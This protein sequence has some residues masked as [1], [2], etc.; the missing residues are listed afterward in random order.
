MKQ[1]FSKSKLLLLCACLFTLWCTAEASTMFVKGTTTPYYKIDNGSYAQMTQN[2]T[3]SDNAVWYY[4]DVASGSTVTFATNGSGSNASPAITFDS[5]ADSYFEYNGTGYG[6]NLTRIK[7][8]TSYILL[9]I[10]RDDWFITG[11]HSYVYAWGNSGDNANWPGEKVIEQNN[12]WGGTYYIGGNNGG[13]SMFLW[14]SN[15]MTPTHLKVFRSDG[16]NN[17]W[18]SS[19]EQ[20]YYKGDLYKSGENWYRDNY[21]M[22]NNI[23]WPV[24]INT[25]KLYLV[26]NANGNPW[27]ANV[28]I[29]MTATDDTGMKFKAENVLLTPGNSGFAFA[30]ML[31]STSND[32]S[33]LNDHRYGSTANSS[34]WLITESQLGMT[35]NNL[36]VDNHNEKNFIVETAGYYNVE[37]DL[38]AM[39]TKVTRVYGAL[40]MHYGTDAGLA[41]GVGTSMMTNDGNTYTLSNVALAENDEFVFTTQLT[42]NWN[43]NYLLG[44]NTSANFWHIT[45]GDLNTELSQSLLAGQGKRFRMDAG[46]AGTYRVVVN[47]TNNSVTLY[48]MATLQGKVIIHLEQT[49]NVSDPV[50]WAYDKEALPN[51]TEIHVDRPD[52]NVI[53]TNRKKLNATRLDDVTVGGRTWWSWEVDDAMTDFWFTRGSYDYANHTSDLTHTDMTDI[54]WRK[55]GEL[56]YT[57]PGTSNTLEDYTRDYYTAAAQEAAVCA[58][59]IDGHEY[60]YF[61]NTPG[62][63]HVYCHAWYTDANGNN[64]DLLQ[65]EYITEPTGWYPGVMCDMVGYDKDG[66]EVWRI[67]L[68]AHGVTVK[69]SGIIFNNGVYKNHDYYTNAANTYPAQQTSD[70]VYSTGT[71]YDY[72][73]VITLGSSLA[74][75][76]AKGVSGPP[77]TIADD[78]VGVYVD[79]NA[80]T[81]ITVDGIDHTV[82]GALY[83]KDLN[84]FITTSYVEKSQQQNGEIDY[85]LDLTNLM[86]SR[87]RYDQSNWVKLTL[88]LNYPGIDGLS[89]TAQADLLE[90]YVGRLLPGGSV[91]AVL[92]DNRNPEMR[93]SKELP[94]RSKC[95][96]SVYEPNVFVTDNFVGT[97]NSGIPGSTRRY[98]FVTPKPQEYATIT[99]AVWGGNNTFYV[100]TMHSY[101]TEGHEFSWMNEADLDGYFRVQWD[102]MKMPDFLRDENNEPNPAYAGQATGQAYKFHAIIRLADESADETTGGAQRMPSQPYKEYDDVTTAYI[103]SPI[104]IKNEDGWVV[105]AVSDT[106]ATRQ[107]RQVR[108]YNVAGQ[109]SAAPFDGMNIIVTD[110][111][112]GT[113]TTAKTIF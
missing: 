69:P 102:I 108:Y 110:Y 97:Q 33:T 50:L 15:T 7:N 13:S 31:G 72:C 10:S 95:T 57:W 100:P 84:N 6:V 45:A 103:V 12:R 48:N 28:G 89:A 59:M 76:I 86:G 62:W 58:V 34:T 41:P 94:K 2:V 79:R 112:D 32:W 54:V 49:A 14:T 22:Y 23:A 93:L 38:S 80:T 64:I 5:S 77:Y 67:D 75:I 47:L 55:S 18:N 60:A 88:S 92:I 68:T 40:Y 27:E 42:S 91:T 21:Q 85:V 101:T 96:E 25:G 26:G 17:E 36:Q 81:T 90:Q 1:V 107:V 29:E 70:F 65:N 19:G 113:R 74:S 37:V 109:E 46:T 61:T 82:Y 51:G 73:G 87:T 39:T 24:L 20:T 71:C 30:T 66:Y 111:T 43:D 106:R 44:A 9:E 3:S 83:C 8:A 99:W 104:D 63:E 78:M 56:Y 11:A 53:A 98:F 35:L 16:N 4:A 105:T 52:R